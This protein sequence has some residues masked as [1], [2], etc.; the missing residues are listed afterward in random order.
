[1]GLHRTPGHFELFGNLGVVTALQQQIGDL[2]LP[3]TQ[4]NRLIFHASSP[5]ELN[6]NHKH[7]AD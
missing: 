6:K 5:Q 4:L 7:R 3:W 1:M 2:L